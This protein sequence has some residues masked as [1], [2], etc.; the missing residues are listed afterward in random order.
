MGGCIF[1]APGPGTMHSSSI[2]NSMG[3]GSFPQPSW[4]VER[5]LVCFLVQGSLASYPGSDSRP[6][7]FHGQARQID[8]IVTQNQQDKFSLV[9]PSSRGN[10]SVYPAKV[11]VA[12]PYLS[13]T[14]SLT[15][16]NQTLASSNTG[17][18]GLKSQSPPILRPK[19]WACHYSRDVS[20]PAR[21]LP[22]LANT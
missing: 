13:I 21:R 17:K 15:H 6:F 16:D 5:I 10:K 4:I 12:L 14:L 22:F 3:L 18:E 8:G 2:F 19:L 1:L 11:A 9:N 7:F 20:S